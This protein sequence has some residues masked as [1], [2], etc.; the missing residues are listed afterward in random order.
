MNRC[1]FTEP[2]RVSMVLRGSKGVTM[3]TCKRFTLAIILFALS[4]LVSA[5]PNEENRDRSLCEALIGVIEPGS[6][7]A[8]V[9][10]GQEPSDFMI[11]IH[12]ANGVG[13]AVSNRGELGC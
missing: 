12:D 10:G 9:D 1:Q 7:H 2:E 8:H 3:K 6:L 11:K 13:L 5:N 4:I